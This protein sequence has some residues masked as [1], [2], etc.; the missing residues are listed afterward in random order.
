MKPEQKNQELNILADMLLQ[1]ELL[2]IE[3]ILNLFTI[4]E[5]GKNQGE[6]TYSE[7]SW[8]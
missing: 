5:I 2:V 4:S 1:T 6:S 3:D 7:P 8:K